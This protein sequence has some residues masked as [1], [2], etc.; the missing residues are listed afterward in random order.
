MRADRLLSMMMLLQAHGTLTAR[1]LAETL[2]V[3]ERTIYRDLDALSAAGIPVCAER[4]PG[5]GCY[6]LDSYRTTLTGLNEGEVRVLFMLSIPAPLIELGVS[7]ELRAA[8]LKL[9]A[10]L[11][12]GRQGDE[13]RVRQRLHLDPTGWAESEEPAPHL[14]T[15]HQAVWQDRWLR[16]AYRAPFDTRI[17]RVVAPYGLVA[18]AGMWYLVGAR[19]D[20]ICVIQV[21]D[22]LEVIILDESFDRPAQ[23][24]LAGFWADWCAAHQA[25]QPH[26]LATV[27]VSPQLISYL[28]W[29]FGYD[30]RERAV[31][32]GPPDAEGWITITLS[33][34]TF[35]Q[36]RERILGLGSAVEVLEPEALRESVRDFAGQTRAIYD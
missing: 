9:T 33:F 29:I 8:L 1:E 5:G 32:A 28:G 26:Y 4:G 22:V 34:E 11:P 15:I 21:V 25:N 6:L 10:S 24:D 35:H 27:R 16:L 14:Q 18:K 19:D 17:E 30:V 31:Q 7:G 13:E 20:H 36:A 2:E 12:A 23:F 3:S